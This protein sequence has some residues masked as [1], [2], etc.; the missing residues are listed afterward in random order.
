LSHLSKLVE[1]WEEE[2]IS[3]KSVS[4]PFLDTGS[5]HG[6]FVFQMFGAFAELERNIIS[7]RTKA[8]L[9]A[10]RKR[11]RIGGRK[12]GLSDRA[13]TKARLAE[14][15]YRDQDMTISQICSDLEISR[16]SFYKYLR[17]RGVP[18][19]KLSPRKNNSL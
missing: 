5:S 6:K 16:G 9:A 2:G 13:K 15:L 10:A 12:K 7:E 18:V 1:G 19:G 14:S 8:G 3:F 11:G 17:H 4:E